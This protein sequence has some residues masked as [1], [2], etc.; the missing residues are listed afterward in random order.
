M[1]H[2]AADRKITNDQGEHTMGRTTRRQVVGLLLCFGAGGACLPPEDDGSTSVEPRPAQTFAA[3]EDALRG[4]DAVRLAFD[5]T[6]EGAAEIAL[7]GTLDLGP[8]GTTELTATGTFGEQP[9]DLVLRADGEIMRWGVAGA[10]EEGPE[11]PAL[12]DA[13]VVGL[14]RMGILHNLARL[15][16]N[17]PPDH[18]DGGVDTWVLVDGFGG[19]DLEGADTAVTFDIAV[20]GQPSGSAT[21]GLDAADLPVVRRQSVMFPTGEMRVIERYSDVEIVR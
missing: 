21:L 5:V 17:A 11:P 14:M 12:R 7:E 15:T 13:L 19:A 4:A 1:S 6:A 2:S 3:L 16:G 18:G 20:D 8:D 10:L 9:V